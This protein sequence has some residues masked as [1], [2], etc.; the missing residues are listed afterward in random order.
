LLSVAAYFFVIGRYGISVGDRISVAGVTGDVID[1]GLVRF[2]LMEFSPT[3]ADLYPTGRIVVFSNAVL[4]Q[5]TTPLFKQ[6]PGTRYTWHEAILPLGPKAD[7]DAVQK[8][9]NS[10]VDPVFKEYDMDMLW[11]RRAFD[12]TDISLNP[13]AP[14]HRLQFS[15]TGPELIARYPV[16]LNRAGEIDEKITRALIEAIQRDEK[17]ANS[18]TGSPKIRSAVKV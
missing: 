9:L 6:L 11:H 5:A 16:D 18:V 13:P 1:V 8:A 12:P 7:Y 17:L 2:Y 4:F 15:D 10:A 3:G 14:E